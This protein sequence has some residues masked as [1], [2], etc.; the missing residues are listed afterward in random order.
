MIAGYTENLGASHSS[1]L[2]AKG[3]L[4][5]LLDEQGET[6]EAR[7]LYQEARGSRFRGQAAHVPSSRGALGV[8]CYRQ[9]SEAGLVQQPRPA[10]GGTVF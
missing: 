7:E 1:T 8:D 4:A 5:T 6:A 2:K 10:A 3:N 9:C